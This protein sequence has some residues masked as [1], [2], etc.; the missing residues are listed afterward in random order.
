MENDTFG[1]IPVT[2]DD[3]GG[4]V[5]EDAQPARRRTLASIANDTVIEAANAAAGGVSAAANFVR[6]GNAVSGW[7]DKN[8]VEAGEASQS[9]AVKSEKQRFRRGVANADDVLDELGA[10]GSYVVNNPVQAAAQAVGSFVGPGMAVKGGRTLASIAGL[11]AARG[12]LAGGAAAGAAMAG[13]DA[14]GTAYELSTK[15]GATDEQAVAAGRQASVLPAVIGGVGGVVGAER[16]VAGAKGFTGNAVSRAAKTAAVEGAQEALE[17]GVTQYEGQRAAQPYDST[18]DPTKGVA[19]AAAMGAA[20]GGATGG[21]VSLLSGGHAAPAPAASAQ[22]NTN[23][24]NTEP[25]A[26]PAQRPS[27]AMGINPDDGVMSRAA[28]LAADMELA[29]VP[30]APTPQEERAQLEATISRLPEQQQREARVE[31]ADADNEALP[32]GVRALRSERV[33]ELADAAPAA[34]VD[35]APE[36]MERGRVVQNFDA[37]Q[38]D[39]PSVAEYGPMIDRAIAPEHQAEF[40]DLLV[41]ATDSARSPAERDAAAEVLHATFSPDQLQSTRTVRPTPDTRLELQDTAPARFG[42]EIDFTQAPAAG[43]VVDPVAERI[44]QLALDADLTSGQP[45]R[46]DQAHALRRS[47]ADAGIPVSVVPHPSGRGYDVAPTARLDPAARAAMPQDEAAAQLPYDQS[48]TG[49]MLA[50]PDGGVRAEARSEAVARGNAAAVQR[51]QVEAERQ[52]RTELGLSNITPVTPVREGGSVSRPPLPFDNAPTGRMV[53]GADG[54]RQERRAEAVNRENAAAP[55]PAPAPAPQTVTSASGAPFA[56]RQAAQQELQRQQL[57]STHEVVPAG[58]DESLGFVLREKGQN[59]RAPIDGQ[60]VEA[61]NSGADRAPNWRTNAIQA[62]RVARGLGIETKGKRLAQVVAEIDASDNAGVSLNLRTPPT[63]PAPSMMTSRGPATSEPTTTV[64]APELVAAD[65]D[66]SSDSSPSATSQRAGHQQDRAAGSG[67]RPEMASNQAPALETQAPAA[68]KSGADSASAGPRPARAA[69]PRST[70]KIEDFGEELKGARKMLYA[71]AY[72]DSMAQAKE[73]DAR[74]H[75]LSKTWPE[76]DYGKL[77]E[78]GTPPAA[79]AMARALR[80]A[81]PTKP[82]SSWKLKGWTSRMESLRGFAEDLVSGTMDTAT[83]AE[84]MQRANLRGV[85]NQAALYEAMGHERSLKGIQLEDHSYSLYE[86]QRYVPP[87]TIW[88]VARAAKGTAFGNWPRELAKGDTREQAIAAFKRRAAE[89][90][91]EQQA[92]TRGATFEIYGKRAGGAREFYI[93]KKIGGNVAELKSG[94]TD[95]QAA[96]QYLAENRSELEDLLAKFKA[97]PPVRSATNSPRIGEDY[98][99][100]ADVTPEQFQ[101]AFG[102]RGVQFGNYVEGGRRQQ[103]LNQ[104]YDALMD[105]AGVLNLPPKALSLGGRLGLAFGARGTGGTD[106][107]AAHYERGNVVINLTKR[108]GAGSMAH[109]W[110]HGLDNYF[111][112]E[113]GDGGTY[114]TQQE[115]GGEGVREEMRAA[116]R[117]VNGAINRTRMQERSRKL[118]DRRTTAYWTTK[119]E[120]SARAFESYV[121]AKLKDQNAGNDYLA[122]V[123]PASAFA[124]EGGYPYPTAGE[125]PVIR[126]AFDNFFQTV[127]TRQ[128]EGGA[129]VL[130]SAGDAAEP[131]RGLSLEQAQQ[132]VQQA[133]AGLANPPPIDVVSRSEELGVGAPDGVM[134][135]AIPGEGRIVLVA[136]AHGSADAVAETVFHEM[137]HLGV[138]NVLP[139]PDYVQAML[140]LAKRDRRVQEYA[141]RWKRE[142]PDARQQLQALRDLGH[143]GSELTAQYQALAIE[144]GLAVVAEE[145]RAQ[146]QAGTRLGL[147]VRTLANWLAS[148]AERMGMDGLAKR[149]RGMTYNEAERFV[150]RA[151]EHA[152]S[153]TGGPAGVRFRAADQTQSPA[154]QRWFGDSK[155]VDANGQPLRV[156]HGTGGDFSVFSRAR[157]GATTGA[158]NTGMG[159]FFTDNAE[160]AGNYARMA[161]ETQAIMPTYLSLKNPLQLEAK[162]MMEAD[163]LLLSGLKPEND[164][165]IIRVAMRDGGT[166][167]VYMVREP[168]Q[169]KSATGNRG[170]FDPSDPDIRYR[171]KDDTPTAQRVGNALKSVTVTNLKQQAGY[172]AADYRGLGLQLLGRRQLVDVYG[173]MLPELR[174]Y[175]DLMARMDADKNEAGSGADQL[176]QDWAKLPDERALAE[177]MHDSTLAQIDPSRDF[178]EGDNKTDWT[179]LQARYNALTQGAKDV[180]ARARDT[181]RQHMRDVRGAIKER[182]ERTEISSER[183]AAMLKRMDDEFFGH[184]KGVYFPLARFGQYVVVVKDA[185]GKVANVS[186][187]ETMAEADAARRQLQQAFPAGKGYAVGKVL[188]AKDF[189]AERDSVGRGFMEQLYGVLDKQGMDTKQ[190]AELEDALGQLYLSS[191]PDL[192]WAKHGIHRK[193]TAGFSQDA[194]RAFAQNVFHGASYLAKL[195]YGDRLQDELGE[196]QRRVDAGSTDSGFDSVKGQQVVDEMVKRHDA[197]MNP[198]T[199]AVSTA[200]TSLGFIFHLGLSPASAMV[201]LTQTALVAYPVMGAKWG[202]K[203]ASAALLK[204][205]GEAARGK[206]DITTSL[207]PEEKAAFDEAVRSGVIDVTMAHDLAGIAQGEDQ[208]VSYKLRPVMRAASWMFHHAEKFNRQV[209]FVAAYRLAREAGAGDKAAF[210]QAVQATYDGHFDY[211]SN[212]RP[213]AMQGNVARV[214]LLFKQYGQNMVYTLARNAHQALKGASPAERAQAGKALGGLLTMHAL[215]AGAL[216]LPMVTT[217]LAAASMLGGDDDEP[218]DAQVALQNMLADTFG[219]KPAEVLAHGLSRLTPWDISGRVGLDKLIFPDVQEGLEGQRLG[220]SAMAAALGPVA[221]IGINALKGVQ[222]MGEGQYQRGLEAMAPSVLRGPLKTWRYGTEGVRDKSGIVV[223]DEVD[224]AALFGQAAGFSPSGVRNAYEGKSAIVQ[225]DRALQARRSALVEQFAMAAMAGDEEGK[226]AAREDIAKFNDKNPNRRIQAMQL[227]QS[228]NMR[229]KRIREAEEGVYL[230]SKRRDALDAGRFATE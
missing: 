64:S 50:G 40:R 145:L 147:R 47:A 51:Q 9:D 119:P 165:A 106:A 90:L 179:R 197:A 217:L 4:Q 59:R 203:K 96:R 95:I 38:P 157:A 226:A 81:V 152:G 8:I 167:T 107:A 97:I 177:L 196:M 15:G 13:G 41:K 3:F 45:L 210:E 189:V 144:E 71:E 48:A 32:A 101:N 139:A 118:D 158:A 221:G 218:W 146:K 88:T 20:L 120:M 35:L 153:G 159:F 211:S 53:A 135:A 27:E 56:T 80:D 230:P 12:G 209:T 166:Q 134:G 192:S 102:F 133:L 85:A 7:I 178:V 44:S 66:A 185:E 161:R 23:E 164:G 140:D 33:Q 213:R 171:A 104:A 138:R 94:F 69:A 17:E 72:G 82:Q 16:L 74:A 215:A 212:N 30:A 128:G 100:G 87:R 19:A 206:N 68:I 117:E 199:N 137:F 57:A 58:G 143:T 168:S 129:V 37:R 39:L 204:A 46:L 25:V 214:V 67:P 49:R 151:I 160:V 115:Q 163:K 223:Q 61:I 105:L 83:V 122:N 98:R 60:A 2:T 21:G 108:E 112:R 141:D 89:L 31:L 154:F 1:G 222:L 188:K 148:V 78:G 111:S 194:R 190:R 180:Y 149:I 11:N 130:F 52:R 132:A 229:Q 24:L 195:R 187:A 79:V 225:H 181:Y 127:D 91:A 156:F 63:E 77:L 75:P 170:T 136:S 202:Y 198:K 169:V 172:K 123:V 14:A 200:L 76:P 227:A 193:G 99:K 110:W 55:A 216:G 70:T 84:A 126:G 183:K 6:P 207:S 42:N 121:I 155:A 114:M 103:D 205:S 224:A 43:P 208:N 228:V 5:V 184:I 174:T 175:S 124:L 73:L 176:A 34:A 93:G 219:Q 26:A 116:F 142:A 131:G 201:N 162:N 113:R 173:G 18:I 62:N 29:P 220:E 92:P 86:G 186:R 28:A 182:I 150:L 191:L 109:E 22:P 36:D 10:V 54:V 125:L 65:A